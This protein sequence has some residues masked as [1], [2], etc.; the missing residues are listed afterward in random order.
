MISVVIPV[1]NEE[2][3]IDLLYDRLSSVLSQ[4]KYDWEIIFVNDGSEDN[5]LEILKRYAS[6]DRRVKIISLSRNFGHQVALSAGMREARGVVCVTMDCDLQDPPELIP[7]MIRK[8]EEGNNIVYARRTNRSDGFLKKLTARVYYKILDLI[9]EVRV[10][11][12]VGDFRLVD[13]KVLTVLNNLPEKCRYLRG[14]VSWVG[15][16]QAFVEFDRPNRCNGKTSYT[17]IRMLELAAAGILSSSLLP[18]KLGMYI[19]MLSMIVGFGFLIYMIGDTLVFNTVYPLYRWLMV[20]V[21]VFFGLS[22][23]LIWIMAEYIGRIYKEETGRPLYII[24]EKTNL[25][26]QVSEDNQLYSP[27]CDC[28]WVEMGERTLNGDRVDYGS[29]PLAAGPDGES[30]EVAHSLQ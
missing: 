26:T 29:D 24:D 10:P 28:S 17:W 2:K 4:L 18:L 16:K 23:I 25:E 27:V 11:Q 19:G 12:N 3:N 6:Q 14:M 5:S 22:F 13:R 8:Y 1:Y 20:V 15:F 9:S 30:L 21:F 7:A